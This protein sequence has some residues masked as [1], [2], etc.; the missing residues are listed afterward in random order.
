MS[1]FINIKYRFVKLPLFILAALWGVWYAH[2]ALASP[3][4]APSRNHTC[5]VVKGG[6]ECIGR[7][8][9]G[10]TG[11]L[12][13]GSAAAKPKLLIRSGSGITKVAGRGEFTCALKSGGSVL[14]WGQMK[15]DSINYIP[16]NVLL[17]APALD[18]AVGDDH[19]CA[20]L[21][22]RE[23]Q[24]WGSNQ[25]GQLGRNDL[26]D[27]WSDRPVYAQKVVL[28]ANLNKVR[29]KLDRVLSLVAGEDHNCTL[30][31]DGNV[32]CWG[33]DLYGNLGNGTGDE[34]IADCFGG[35][36]CR[37]SAVLVSGFS[38]SAARVVALSAGNNHTCAVKNDGSVWCWGLNSTGQLGN[39]SSANSFSP[40]KVALSVPLSDVSGG[41]AHTCGFAAPVT[42]TFTSCSVAP[43]R[44]YC[45]GENA[46]GQVTG[47]PTPSPVFTPTEK[48][49]SNM[50]ITGVSAGADNTCFT[51]A[52]STANQNF[53]FCI[54]DN[55]KGQ[56]V[57]QIKTPPRVSIVVPRTSL[58]GATTTNKSPVIVDGI[59]S[60][61][62]GNAAVSWSNGSTLQSGSVP[63]TYGWIA[64]IPLLPGKNLLTYK[65]SDFFGRTATDSIQVFFRAPD[66]V[67]SN[68]RISTSSTFGTVLNVDMC[69]NS[70]LSQGGFSLNIIA[71]GVTK[72]FPFPN[73]VPGGCYAEQW[74]T[75]LWNLQQGSTY[76]VTAVVDSLNQVIEENELNNSIT[77]SLRVPVLSAMPDL[78]VSSLTITGTSP[79]TINAT[80]KN[81]G[82]ASAGATVAYVY[83]NSAYVPIQ[84]YAVPALLPG[85]TYLVSYSLSP[86]PVAGSYVAGAI[87]DAKNQAVELIEGNNVASANF[88][89]LAEGDMP[90]SLSGLADILQSA[91]AT[92][93]QLFE[94]AKNR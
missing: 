32:R 92:L 15:E 19:A 45:W 53:V 61:Y 59:A 76:S 3:T 91:E 37:K 13:P 72:S 69:N 35:D 84:Q 51:T 89:V 58:S 14:C 74:A 68:L 49:F 57:P 55:S 41:E 67:V 11:A 78:I 5:Y 4:I 18:I 71:N 54:G 8:A 48:T 82:T 62:V 22:T 75:Y 24:C 33:L 43:R 56:S 46:K 30:G 77:A 70:H 12:F 60:N 16:N 66:L 1:R 88:N 39:L 38:F 21:N 28:D 83:Y 31:D 25:Y 65:V 44:F 50:K 23:V 20:L 10:E 9:E 85:Q 87:A 29:V 7:F 17:S 42:C 93:Q 81:Q 47:S 73:P 6:V 27:D 2:Q 90:S 64:S 26:A 86:K 80:I 63:P 79:I 94:A 40:V 52:T 36:P 34:K